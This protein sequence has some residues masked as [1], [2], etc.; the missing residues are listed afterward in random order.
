MVYT[1]RRILDIK[2]NTCAYNGS[3]RLE[4]TLR[5]DLAKRKL[6]TKEISIKFMM[7]LR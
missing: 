4:E 3:N 6:L 1:R 2:T 5:V 7:E